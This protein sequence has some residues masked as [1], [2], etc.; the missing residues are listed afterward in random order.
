[1]VARTAAR[2]MTSPDPKANAL[3]NA[4][5]PDYLRILT[6]KS[7][8]VLLSTGRRLFALDEPVNAVYFPLTSMVSI[9]AGMKRKHPQLEVAPVGNEGAIG[10]IEVVHSQPSLGTGIVRLP[11]AAMRVP[12]RVF[13]EE[14]GLR[15][16]MS[17]LTSIHLH[18]LLREIV[19][20]AVCSR[21]HNM[22]QRCARSI[23]TSHDHAD[24][25]TFPLTQDFLSHILGV[26]RATVNQAFGDLKRSGLI[27]YVRGRLTVVERVRLE[28]RSCECYE[29]IRKS[30]QAM[31]GPA[32]Q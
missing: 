17:E 3:L 5:E 22:E 31:M 2:Q 15:R 12:S 10:A 24:G 13:E 20:G 27:A 9:M 32:P 18:A 7:S 26:R 21:I 30:Y 25:D 19:Q 28:A 6:D 1:M 23:L 8:I 11:G 14:A 29:I 16:R 4:L